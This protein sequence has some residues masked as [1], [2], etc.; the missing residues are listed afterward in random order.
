MRDYPTE[1]PLHCHLSWHQAL[2]ELG[3][4]RYGRVMELYARE[5]DPTLFRARTLLMDTAS[6]LW[7]L[8]IYGCAERPL[9]WAEVCDL[10][11][12]AA[13]KPGFAFADAHAALAYAGAGDDEAMAGLV[14]GLRELAAQGHA[15]AKDVVLPLVLGVEAFARGAYEEAIARIEPL[16]P[17]LVRI[18]GS[19]AQREVFE[20]TLLQAYLR[21]GRFEAAEALLRRRVGR[22]HSARD[23]FWLGRAR[24]AQGDAAGARESFDLAGRSWR[25]ADETAPEQVAFRSARLAAV[26]VG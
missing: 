5:L 11:R 18:G 4:G 16:M 1:A 14:A 6:L 7:R 23:F 25:D 26:G 12:R 17:D 15:V 8:H 21:A 20:D 2:F 24:A 10:A 19:N 3:A 22:R 13:A 9:P